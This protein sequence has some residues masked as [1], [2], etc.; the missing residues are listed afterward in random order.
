[1]RDLAPGDPESRVPARPRLPP[2]LRMGDAAAARRRSR[3]GAPLPGAGPQLSRAGPRGPGRARFRAG[4]PGRPDACRR[5]T[6]P[7]PRS[8]LEQRNWADARAEIERELAIVPESAGA[9]ALQR[10]I[11][12]EEKRGEPARG[13]RRPGRLSRHA[14]SPWRRRRIR[15]T[16]GRGSASLEARDLDASRRSTRAAARALGGGADARGLRP[17]AGDAA[18]GG[19]AASPARPELLRLL[20]GVLFVTGD[21]PRLR[22]RAQEGGGAGAPRRA[23]PFH[24]GH[25]LRRAAAGATGRGP[26]WRR[27]PQPAP[28]NP[29]YPYWLARLDYD[30]GA[31]R[32]RRRGL[33]AGARPRSWLRE[34]PRQPRPLP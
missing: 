10:R 20:G 6:S 34:G 11:E 17:R 19:S 4:G 29:L 2:P 23:Q 16:R 22:D 24:A 30:D 1:M 18:R 7:S 3:L 14:R 32:G 25:V 31:I 12:A 26:S 5:S 15:R 28:R 9:L 21:V 8:T 27:W 13:P 33:P